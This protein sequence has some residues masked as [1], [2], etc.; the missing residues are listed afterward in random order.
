[1]N[2][3]TMRFEFKSLL[4]AIGASLLVA[5]V[6]FMTPEVD[7][8]HKGGGSRG[9]VRHSSKGGGGSRAS[10]N[11]GGTNRG[12]ANRGGATNRGG[13]VN[14]GGS[15]NRGGTANRGNPN[16]AGTSNRAGTPNR[17]RTPNRAGTPNRGAS[18]A[19][20]R[21]GRADKRYSNRKS[22]RNDYRR[23]HRRRAIVRTGVI[24]ATRPRYSRTVI[25]TGTRYYYY[26]GVYYVASG[27]GYVVVAA[28]YGAVV[29]A[30]PA[31]TTVVYAGSTPYYYYGGTYY[32][33][34]DQAVTSLQEGADEDTPPEG[35]EDPDA[36]DMIE[37]DHNFEVI[38]P[39][40]GT[41]VPYLPDEADELDIKGKTYFEYEGTYYQPFVSDG[42]TIYMVVT[43]PREEA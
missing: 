5:T 34:T 16:R 18:R 33:P 32:A 9:S 19:G 8:Q 29:H 24:I 12:S 40:F 27:T 37:S 13:T 10:T 4:R 41:T 42:D 35:E 25:V 30:V 21:G 11:R 20:Y 22:A 39:P 26:G 23:F 36:P 17:A 7:A 43:D 2:R 31:P 38:A 1:M 15:A 6:M 28:P 14:R 3:S